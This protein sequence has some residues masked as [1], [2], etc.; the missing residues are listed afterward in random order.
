VAKAMGLD[1]ANRA[2]RAKIS[3]L[4]KTWIKNGMFKVVDGL[5]DHREKRNFIEVGEAAND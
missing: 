1:A 5:D 3:A 4:L 2:H